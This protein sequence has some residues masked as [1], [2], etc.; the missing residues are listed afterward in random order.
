MRATDII[1]D[2]SQTLVFN[3]QDFTDLTVWKAIVFSLFKKRH[4]LLKHPVEAERSKYIIVVQQLTNAAY[5]S[6]RKLPLSQSCFHYQG[7]RRT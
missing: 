1:Y 7:I 5:T 6:P 3:L 2:Q 4:E